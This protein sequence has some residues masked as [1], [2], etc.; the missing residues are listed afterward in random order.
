[1]KV[2]IGMPLGRGVVHAETAA[3][4]FS[5]VR[6]LKN[7]G[8]DCEFRSVTFAEVGMA[9]DMLVDLFLRS[10]CDKLL[11]I[12]DDMKFS[13]KIIADMVRLNKPYVGVIAPKREIDLEAYGEAYVKRS[14]LKGKGRVD[15]ARSK[16]LTFVGRL[17]DDIS[18]HPD[19]K[20]LKA[21]RVGAGILL[22][23]R[24]VFMQ[25]TRRDKSLKQYKSADGGQRIMGFF[26]RLYS[27]KDK[28][29]LS[30]DLSFCHR[31]HVTLGEDVW[32]YVKEGIGHIGIMTFEG[33]PHDI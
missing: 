31:W 29:T 24:D 30:E 20:F 25:L 6:A 18:K 22:L 32:V 16:A 23:D 8:F 10:D 19:R 28:T 27:D 2:M 5:L 13:A 4:I 1:M 33:Q 26:E 7:G 14:D 12:D 9:R 21:E 17:E 11:F 3:S 15:A